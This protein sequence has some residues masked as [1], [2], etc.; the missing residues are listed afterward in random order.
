MADF[1]SMPQ[2]KETSQVCHEH[3]T[4]ENY[5]L[6]TFLLHRDRESGE[7]GTLT[8]SGTFQARLGAAARCRCGVSGIHTDLHAGVLGREPRYATWLCSHSLTSKKDEGR[9]V[10]CH[11]TLLYSWFAVCA[12]LD[13]YCAFIS[14]WNCP[15]FRYVSTGVGFQKASI[16]FAI[17]I[18]FS[19]SNIAQTVV[20]IVMIPGMVHIQHI[21]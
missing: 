20:L 9:H 4:L 2:N 8:R 11:N 21:L 12:H 10:S 3:Q 7:A 5:L 1:K 6:F 18:S 19:T 13:I 15:V 14:P 16:S 17:L